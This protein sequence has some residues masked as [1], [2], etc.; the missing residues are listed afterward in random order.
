VASF[1]KAEGEHRRIPSVFEERSQGLTTKWTKRVL[2]QSPLSACSTKFKG[3]LPMIK[4][5]TW[6]VNSIK[7]RLPIVV[8]WVKENNPDVLLLQETKTED[9]NFPAM[10]FEDLGYNVAVVGQKSYN[11]VAILAKRPIEDIFDLPKE[12]SF[13]K[14]A[15]DQGHTVFII[16][17][18]NPN[19]KHSNK[20]FPDYIQEGP[21]AALDA[22]KKITGEQ[23]VNAIG[24]CLG[25]N[26]TILHSRL[27]GP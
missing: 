9:K 22:I 12:K 20:N 4:V 19:S 15:V 14:W 7:A 26:F 1:R 2:L 5:I 21:L 3:E 23:Q 13:I 27:P 25:G 18:V 10:E 17:W 16:S 8:D 24:H 6:N 11:G